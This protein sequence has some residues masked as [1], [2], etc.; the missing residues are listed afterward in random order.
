MSEHVVEGLAK[1]ISNLLDLQLFPVDLV[2]N[3]VDLLVHL[4][5]A[6]LSVLEPALG[7]LVLSLD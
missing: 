5:D 1:L 3:V 2:L 4:G 7:G 6:H